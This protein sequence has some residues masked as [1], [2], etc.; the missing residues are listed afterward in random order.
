M[1]VPP[2]PAR[3]ILIVDD[4]YTIRR[5][6]Q[7]YLERLGWV[8]DQDGDGD[9]ALARLLAEGAPAYDVL[10]VDLRMPGM[11]GPALYDAVVAARPALAARVVLSTGNSY[12][13][14][15]ARFIS[16]TGC[17]VLNKPF[18]LA[19]LREVVERVAGQP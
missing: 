16:R 8:V 15:A 4:E 5:A 7:R 14:G 3:R 17:A 9:A 18:E 19:E 11:S 13:E 12:D 1:S 6:M 2:P 10:V